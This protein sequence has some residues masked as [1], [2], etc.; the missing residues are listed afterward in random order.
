MRCFDKKGKN[1]LISL[2]QF[3][4]IVKLGSYPVEVIEKQRDWTKKELQKS[5]EKNQ[6]VI[7]TFH[8][9]PFTSN[10]FYYG[11][12]AIS[13]RNTWVPMFEESGVVKLVLNGHS[14]LYERS[15]KDGI[16]YVVSGPFGGQRNWL[17]QL[18]N[19]Y[20]LSMHPNKDTFSLLKVTNQTIEMESFDQNNELIDSFSIDI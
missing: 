2:S 15:L 9:A 19:H 14:H 11:P 3:F 18:S 20:R 8:H 13:F 16:M 5:K 10:V 17:P 4:K 6:K 12:V 1:V 7:I